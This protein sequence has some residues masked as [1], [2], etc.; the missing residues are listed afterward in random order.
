LENT[1]I[2]GSYTFRIILMITW[3]FIIIKLILENV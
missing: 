2:V 1:A 3:P